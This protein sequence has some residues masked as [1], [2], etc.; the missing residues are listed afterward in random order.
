MG[1]KIKHNLILIGFMGS[2]KTSVGELLAVRLGYSFQDTDLLIEQ[3]EKDTISNIFQVKGEGYFRD[4]ETTLIEDLQT[5][6]RNTVLSAGGG[7]PLREQNRKLLRELGFV[8]YL[9]ASA[10]EIIERLMNDTTRPL[11][12]GEELDAKVRSMLKIRIPIYEHAAHK[13]ILV[14]HKTPEEITDMVIRAY[15][16]KD[17]ED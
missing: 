12:Q 8:V 16:Y 13:K 14:D 3:T 2:G 11:L 10:E 7:L 9:E 6:L 4:L 17:E 15:E 5:N 1:D